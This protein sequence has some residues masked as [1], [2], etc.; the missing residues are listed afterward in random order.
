VP[1]VQWKSLHSCQWKIAS[2]ICMLSVAPVTPPPKYPLTHLTPILVMNSSR[3]GRLLRFRRPFVWR[4]LKTLPAE[5]RSRPAEHLPHGR[6]KT[7][8]RGENRKRCQA[9]RTERTEHPGGSYP[10]DRRASKWAAS[11]RHRLLPVLLCGRSRGLARG[12][13]WTTKV[14]NSRDYLISLFRCLSVFAG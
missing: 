4:P 7:E 6:K 11:R 10:L 9:R 5:M 12:F 13:R 8:V 14:T 2:S 1:C 3:Y